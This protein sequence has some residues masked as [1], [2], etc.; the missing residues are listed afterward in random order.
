MIGFTPQVA[1]PQTTVRIH[2]ES[3]RV[4]L[5][6]VTQ[7]DLSIERV[8]GLYGA[9]IHLRFD[10]EVLEVVDADPTQEGIQLEPGTLPLPDYVVQNQA[11]NVQGTIHYAAT[12]LQPNKPGD[13][14]GVIARIMFRGK[15]ASTSPIEFEQFVLADTTGGDIEAVSQDGQIKVSA[16][17]SWVFAAVAGSAV[18]LIAGVIGFAIAKRK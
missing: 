8:S 12:Q 15:K 3:P 6:Q 2:P 10:P 1:Q 14:D 7:V 4:K 5:G 9:E 17:P 13:G 16:A 18:L 11:D